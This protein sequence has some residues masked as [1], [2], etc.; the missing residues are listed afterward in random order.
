ML[1]GGSVPSGY[2]DLVSLG[3]AEGTR[4]AGDDGAAD[5]VISAAL[6]EYSAGRAGEHAVL[7]LVGAARLLVPVVPAPGAGP[8][9][10]VAP[11][12]VGA[13]GRLAVPAFTCVESMR[14]WRAEA[15]PSPAATADVCRQA[16][17]EDAAV[18]LDVAGPV[19]LAI[20]GARLAAMAA[21]QPVPGPED[22]PDI[23]RTVTA[24]VASAAPGAVAR[25]RSGEP[26]SDLV[27][28]VGLPPGPAAPGGEWAS[29]LGE[30]L[31]DALGARLRRGFDLVVTRSVNEGGD[32]H[33]TRQQ[34]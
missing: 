14:R 9:E 31:A 17:A 33:A 28:E 20:E 21:D 27:V 24:A 19:M 8:A 3:P 30:A 25:L 5:P 10:M 15:R 1:I 4:F 16:L 13:D 34:S 32:G 12:L 7:A 2:S 26:G 11:R 23:A 6:A 22:D 18:V 29:R